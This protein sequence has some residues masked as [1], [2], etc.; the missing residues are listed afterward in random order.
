MSPQSDESATIPTEKD[1]TP[2]ADRSI[3]PNNGASDKDQPITE[4]IAE[5]SSSVDDTDAEPVR[6]RTAVKPSKDQRRPKRVSLLLYFCQANVVHSVLLPQSRQSR[7]SH[8]FRNAH[9]FPVESNR[10]TDYPEG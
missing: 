2:L 10:R 4:A 1:V 3:V 6:G 7:T 5:P 8:D 9:D